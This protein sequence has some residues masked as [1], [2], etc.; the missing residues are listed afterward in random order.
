MLT[1][2]ILANQQPI[3]KQWQ[4][5]VRT[6]IVEDEVINNGQEEND[7]AVHMLAMLEAREGEPDD[8]DYH[9]N[10]REPSG[11]SFSH[12]PQPPPLP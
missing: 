3:L 2:A 7:P 8:E 1:T 12:Q 11:C 6:M 5:L 4:R 10:Y 9:L